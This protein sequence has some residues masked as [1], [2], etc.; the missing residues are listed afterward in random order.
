MSIISTLWNW[1]STPVSPESWSSTTP[2][3]LNPALWSVESATKQGYTS[4]GFGQE[5]GILPP[6]NKRDILGGLAGIVVIVGVAYALY[7]Y[8][9]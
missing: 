4:T 2:S 5:T 7:K 8:F 1:A 9:K 6:E 3:P